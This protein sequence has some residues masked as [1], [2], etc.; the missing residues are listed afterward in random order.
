MKSFKD[1]YKQIEQTDKSD[2]IEGVNL[3]SIS[4]IA[5]ISKSNSI[6]KNIQNLK[7]SDSELDKKLN[8][9]S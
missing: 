2:L 5:L 6:N 4:S 3:R 8:L 1:H 7:S 9:L